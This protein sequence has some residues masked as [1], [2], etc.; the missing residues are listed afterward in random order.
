RGELGEAFRDTGED[1]EVRAGLPGRW[2]RLVE[3]VDER[4]QVGGGEVVLLV[5]RRGGEHDV[6]VEGRAV[7]AEV[8]RREQ[9]ELPG[10]RVV[11]PDDLVRAL[12]LRTL[13][14]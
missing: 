12:V 5:P 13:D 2:H 10:R 6:R 1:V 14:V 4:V 9:V 11:A 7:H 3:R 8:D